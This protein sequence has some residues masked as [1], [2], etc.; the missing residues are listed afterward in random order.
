MPPGA[1]SRCGGTHGLDRVHDH[2]LGHEFLRLLEDFIGVGLCEDVA[3]APEI[4]H[5][6]GA[7]LG[8]VLHFLPH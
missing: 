2:H 3:L 4:A 5:A 6:V 7:H 8:F 1:E